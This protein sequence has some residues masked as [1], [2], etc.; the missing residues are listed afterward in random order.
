MVTKR[1][2]KEGKK[3]PRRRVG[4]IRS[5]KFAPGKVTGASGGVSR[6]CTVA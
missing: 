1:K 4:L 5:M 3:Q 2:E 6:A